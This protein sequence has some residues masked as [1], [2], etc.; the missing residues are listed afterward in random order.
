MKNKHLTLSDR[1]V[2]QIGIEQ[3]KTFST[4]V[5]KL[6]KDPSTISKE[7]RRNRG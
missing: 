6:G 2:I 1:N 3:L 7:V 5:A 4:I